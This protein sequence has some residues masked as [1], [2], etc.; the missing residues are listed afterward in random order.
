[1]AL[2][3]TTMAALQAYYNVIGQMDWTNA[4]GQVTLG[5]PAAGTPT[6]QA[7]L[8]GGLTYGP[9]GKVLP[10]TTMDEIMGVD[11]NGNP[12]LG[13]QQLGL[14]QGEATGFVNGAPT[15]AEQQ[16]GL[17][18][19]NTA[20]GMNGPRSAFDQQ[21]YLHGLNAS[22]LSNAVDAIQGNKALASFQA[23]Q[24]QVQ[25]NTLDSLIAHI[26]GNN[27]SGTIPSVTGGGSAG[28]AL[29][30]AYINAL[31]APNKINAPAWMQLDPDSQQFLL[32]AYTKA[33][34]SANDVLNA[35]H[36]TLPGFHAPV[37]NPGTGAGGV[38]S[39]L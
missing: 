26:T 5:T 34:Y 29:T 2:D 22:G 31:P 7:L 14:S 23:P 18:I 20:A 1:M 12:T 32:G 35:V 27:A 38:Q 16:L 4:L 10:T 28:P 9:G 24:T 15:V 17:G 36:Q 8:A 25:P 37:A 11:A 3:P 6:L 19:L 21:A 13:K 33:G 30:Q 39:A